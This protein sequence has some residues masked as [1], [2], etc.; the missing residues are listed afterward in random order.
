MA[1][2]PSTQGDGG[3]V[4]VSHRQVCLRGHFSCWRRP[5]PTD[6]IQR[7]DQTARQQR[8]VRGRFPHADRPRIWA[9]N[10]PATVAPGHD[11]GRTVQP[12]RLADQSRRARQSLGRFA[13]ANSR[14]PIPTGRADTDRR[15]SRI[16]FEGSDRDGRRSPRFL[17]R[18]HRRDRQCLPARHR[19]ME[20]IRII[21]RARTCTPVGRF[22][23]HC[24]LAKKQGLSRI[25][26]RT[27]TKHFG[28]IEAP[29]TT[30]PST[31]PTTQPASRPGGWFD[32]TAKPTSR[33][34]A[35]QRLPEYEK[36]S[37]YFNLDNGTGKDPW[38][39]CPGQSQCGGDLFSAMA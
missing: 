16:G 32:D 18:R 12:A 28:K 25:R 9:D 36:L 35:D 7:P 22:A 19:A 37:V 38:H 24:G 13:R 27:S 8:R 21:K 6:P 5:Q 2:D 17:A 20:A 15:N 26:P 31:Q 33:P 11:G 29:P 3:T 30:R 4:Y 39:L 14:R 10:A 1:L 23:S 34:A